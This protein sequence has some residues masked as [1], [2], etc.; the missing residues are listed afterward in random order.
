MKEKLD[1]ALLQGKALMDDLGMEFFLVG[2]TLLGIVRENSLL[3]HDHDIDVAVVEDEWTEEKLKKARGYKQFAGESK[4][5][6]SKYGHIT[7]SFDQVPFDLFT[8][9]R[10]G[11]RV[12]NNP[13]GK[14][15]IWF[16][17][18]TI[19]K[20]FSEVNYRGMVWKAPRLK[21]QFLDHMFGGWHTVDKEFKWETH[22]LNYIREIDARGYEK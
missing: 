15:G 4:P 16:P 6:I 12:Y 9:I 22:S 13:L 11:D 3:E 7:F 8:Y 1:N 17:P 20:P 18:E 2:G 5:G 14:H 19:G 21:E 10:I